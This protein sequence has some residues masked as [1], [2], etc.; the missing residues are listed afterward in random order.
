MIDVRP[1]LAEEALLLVRTADD[2]E[3][4]VPARALAR[5]GREAGVGQAAAQGKY[6]VVL[7]VAGRELTTGL[8]VISDPKLPEAPTFLEM[9][10][11]EY[12]RQMKK[13]K[14]LELTD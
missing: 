1:V 11:L 14:L 3:V 7:D 2:L 5:R 13:M 4:A 8:T 6:R 9:E 10:E 12:E